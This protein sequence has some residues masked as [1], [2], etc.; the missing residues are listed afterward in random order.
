MKLA[1]T[2]LATLSVVGFSIGEIGSTS[3]SFSNTV[4]V[5]ASNHLI[6]SSANNDVDKSLPP[7]KSFLN[8]GK[9]RAEFGNWS[10]DLHFTNSYLPQNNPK[11]NRLIQLEKKS[12]RYESKNWQVIVGDSHEELGRGIALSLYSEP[13]F[14]IDNTLEGALVKYRPE[15][16]EVSLWGGRINT[17]VNPVAINPVDMRMKD[18]NVLMASGSLGYKLSG[19]N[20][21][22][23]HYLI[24]V[25]QRKLDLDLDKRLQTVGLTFA[26]ENILNSIDLYV[27]SNV[28]VTD[29]ANKG[30]W[31]RDPN[32]SA[33]FASLSWSKSPWTL[34]AEL[35]DYRKFD[36]DFRRPP[37]LEE[38]VPLVNVPN[39]I[40]DVT[41]A[42]IYAE[43]RSLE[44]GTK[45]YSSFL[46]G[47][48][49]L[50]NANFYHAVL[51]NKIPLGQKSEVEFKT[52]YRWLLNHSNISHG[53]IK[54]K[55][56][57]LPGQMV[58][59]EFK[60]QY[61][62]LQLNTTPTL[63]DRNAVA[64]T[65]SFSELWNMS[66]GLEYVPTNDLELGKEFFNLGAS[67]KKGSLSSR[68]F[69]GK[70]SGG[71]QCAGG[72]CRQVPAYSGAML[73]ASYLF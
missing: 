25:N 45:I 31:N 60:K 41:A 69:I 70:T 15:N 36:C 32:A 5:S 28:M 47:R 13:V 6:F 48:D 26:Q 30:H 39:N 53:S 57:T 2:F 51:G 42:R 63:E 29:K 44:S 17:L 9:A 68:A 71:A 24:T 50:E 34:K 46:Y 54:G 35:K 33:S 19:N 56:K 10:G 21:L 59:L 43:N 49:R 3:D 14:G 8:E 61:S 20:R 27:E 23:G 64:I 18:R 52:G 40:G 65:Y 58:E 22:G 62:Q 1:F 37:S 7:V 16:L 67:Y 38:D 72:V 73:E 12:L 4:R 55:I 11:T 66:A